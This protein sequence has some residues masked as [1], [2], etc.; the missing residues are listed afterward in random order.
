[1]RTRLDALLSPASIAVVGAS[2]TP[3]NGYNA[4]RNLVEI[5]YGGT[6]H[7]VSPKYREI[8]GR[9]CFPRLEDLPAV[10]DAIYVGI[11]AQRA[12]D[13]VRR[14]GRLG[15]RAAVVHAGGFAETGEAGAR[16]QRELAAAAAESG[17]VLCGPNT[18]GVINVHDRSALYGASMPRELQ[19]G[20]IGA[21]FQSGS[22]LLA[23]M[24]AG[25][26]LR[27][28]HLVST[29]N[30]ATVDLAD[31]FDYLLDDERTRLIVGFVEAV[32]QPQ[33][34]LEVVRRAAGM[35]KPVILL[36]PG[37]T[38]AGRQAALA[39]TGS[40]AGSDEV[41]D[42]VFRKHGVIRAHGLDELI[43]L[44]VLFS[45]VA[46]HPR[47]GGVAV[48]CVS[49]GE[50]AIVLDAA[51]AEQVPLARLQPATTQAL[52]RQ[53][54][55]HI[56]PANPLDM[57]ATGLYE[58]ALYRQ[59]LVTMAADDDCGLL[60]VSQDFPGAMGE[61]QS[62][63]YQD[64]ARAFV[65]AAAAID[66]PLVVLSNLSGDIDPGAHAI[67]AAG[68]V[69]LLLGT[70]EGL[71]A[72]AHLLR[73]ARAEGNP[74]AAAPGLNAG[75]GAADAVRRL[76][77]GARGPLSEHDSKALLSRF[78]IRAAKDILAADAMSAAA[79]GDEIGY[80]VVLKIASADIPHKTE[81][82][83]V[84]LGL[85]SREEVLSACEDVLASARR[86]APAARIDGLSVQ[87]QVV[88]GV[89]VIAGCTRDEQF[90]PVIL[91]G[92]GGVFVEVFRDVALA[93]API[94]H[95]EAHALIRSIRGFPLLD[96]ARGRPRGDL[97]ALADLLVRLSD[98]AVQL[99][100]DLQAVDINP[101]LV[102]PEGRGVV[103]ADALVIPASA[104][105]P[106]ARA[107]REPEPAR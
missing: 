76:L 36:K 86:L 16:L 39:H 25:R 23:V 74:C 26:K 42:A 93:L 15:V 32:R 91:F 29:G 41:I 107:S 50:M 2:P 40:L 10:P 24:N 69:P 96:G 85:A 60:L 75:D 104:A 102:L 64:A 51:H 34:F 99:G 62:L 103:A 45:G 84:R 30:E 88:G 53:L 48:T 71:K 46:R 98:M 7:P 43:E 65:G 5:G 13:E 77:R 28:S 9:P 92:L 67:L 90:G 61:V 56:R 63:R 19:A 68:N 35:R 81:V 58:P 31:Y 21:V 33:R 14:A 54:P 55:G 4:L 97:E 95:A 18:L 38:E 27:F 22:I 105:G 106:A 73:F 101:V 66:K 89:E 52:Q 87:E 100:D 72:V 17:I 11:G 47:R 8:L 80:P 37:R 94:G 44:A 70:G 82:G 49:G 6:I 12:V 3:G 78:G 1:M 83:G 59:A 57:T 20:A 79:A